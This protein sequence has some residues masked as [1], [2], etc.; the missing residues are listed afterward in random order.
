MPA[1]HSHL[2]YVEAKGDKG[3]VDIYV[4]EDHRRIDHMAFI[5]PKGSF[6]YRPVYEGNDCPTFERCEHA[7][8]GP[9]KQPSRFDIRSLDGE[10]LSQSRI[11]EVNDS[12]S[13]IKYYNGC[14]G[15][16]LYSG[17][18]R[19]TVESELKVALESPEPPPAKGAPMLGAPETSESGDVVIPDTFCDWSFRRQQ[20]EMAKKSQAAP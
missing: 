20:A 2:K 9:E 5:S 12:V 15:G 10:P 16:R 17:K 6:S 13:G 1:S 8:A 11:F 18:N 7:A 14:A 3:G 4:D 19:Q